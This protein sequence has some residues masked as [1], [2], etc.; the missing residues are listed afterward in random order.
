MKT[1]I[2]H[3]IIAFLLLVPFR[4]PIS[5]VMIKIFNY[6]ASI[7]GDVIP[8]NVMATNV[9]MTKTIYNIVISAWFIFQLEKLSREY[10]RRNPKGSDMHIGGVTPP[11]YWW[12]F[13]CAL[14]L[15][16]FNCVDAFSV[17]SIAFKH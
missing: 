12:T 1:K 11:F 14:L 7:S 2:T 17:Y 13:A 5:I 3:L 16:T 15:V 9:I 8:V 10:L 4:L 6:C